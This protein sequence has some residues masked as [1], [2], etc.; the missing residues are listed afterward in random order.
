MPIYFV[1]KNK[2][3]EEVVDM[4]HE[5]YITG[6]KHDCRSIVQFDG[7]MERKSRCIK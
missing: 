1:V 4:L 2:L 6:S 7:E 3:G 5:I